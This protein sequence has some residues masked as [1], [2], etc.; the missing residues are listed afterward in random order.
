MKF[1]V[2]LIFG[3]AF[4]IS[5][6]AQTMTD[7]EFDGL[8]GKVKAVKTYDADFEL[9]NGKAGQGV[10]KLTFGSEYDESGNVTQTSNY[11]IGSRSIYSF[12][13]G[14]KTSRYERFEVPG[15]GFFSAAPKKLEKPGD[16]DSRYTTKYKYEYDKRGR[17]I[18]EKRYGNDKVLHS[19]WAYRYDNKGRLVEEITYDDGKSIT[20]REISTFDAADNI[21]E[22]KFIPVSKIAG[23]SETI[24][25]FKNYKFDNQ[26]NWTQRHQTTI[27]FRDGSE[28]RLESILIREIIYF[29]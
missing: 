26:G 24:H 2:F 21:I 29:N 25:L 8:K 16:R 20:R 19:N 14:D 27:Y 5:T 10:Q 17:I 4:C 23:D 18:V 9:K 3:A 6:A 12:I 15:G 11:M 1:L 22:R 7:R 13:D 28:R